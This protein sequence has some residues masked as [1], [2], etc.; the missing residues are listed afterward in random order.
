MVRESLVSSAQNC[1]KSCEFSSFEAQA[2][3]FFHNLVAPERTLTKGTLH[4]RRTT[5]NVQQAALDFE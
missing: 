1:A 5:N 3:N 2:T 4:K